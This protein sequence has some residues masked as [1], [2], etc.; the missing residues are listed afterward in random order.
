MSCLLHLQVRVCITETS[1]LRILAYLFFFFQILS[2]FP[3]DTSNCWH[4]ILCI[5]YLCL[6]SMTGL[7][8]QRVSVR[9]GWPARTRVRT[10][11]TSARTCRLCSG[12]W[13]R[14]SRRERCY[15]WAWPT[16]PTSWNIWRCVL[17]LTQT[18]WLP[19]VHITVNILQQMQH[20]YPCSVM[21]KLW[22]TLYFD[23]E[24]T[25]QYSV[26]MASGKNFFFHYK[27]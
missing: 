12:S 24:V 6:I 20:Y 27:K 22:F 18:A 10:A 8:L 25:F 23:F 13:W 3:F 26:S 5:A 7:V 15:A 2:H 9:S 1:Q 19:I 21:P 14:R 11:G 16:H 4:L 17:F